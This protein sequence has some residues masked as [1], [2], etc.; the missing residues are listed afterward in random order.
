MTVIKEELEKQDFIKIPPYHLVM[1]ATK[2]ETFGVSCYRKG[3]S[4]CKQ[5]MIEIIKESIKD[6][7]LR[8][9]FLEKIEVQGDYYS[10][11]D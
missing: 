8:G 6:E 7:T 3:F 2:Y 9:L 1:E 5:R 10:Y 4:H 11:L